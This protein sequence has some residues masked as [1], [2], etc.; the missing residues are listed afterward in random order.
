M[1]PMTGPARSG[2]AP[3][4]GRRCR[5]PGRCTRPR[6]LDYRRRLDRS[7]DAAPGR[8]EGQA[9]TLGW[10]APGGQGRIA[11]RRG[12]ARSDCSAGPAGG[13]NPGR[14]SSRPD[15]LMS[16]GKGLVAG[17]V[18]IDQG[19]AGYMEA[20]VGITVVIGVGKVKGGGTELLARTK[21]IWA[22]NH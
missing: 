6:R 20:K 22:L 16:Q 3:G 21:Q 14:S 15:R 12:G 11:A 13:G 8:P 5:P 1:P 2:W 19:L 9:P 4:L 7:V 17:V 10:Q 18:Q